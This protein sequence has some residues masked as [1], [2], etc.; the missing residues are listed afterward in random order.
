MPLRD[1][2]SPPRRFR[3]RTFRVSETELARLHAGIRSASPCRL[4]ER[5][6]YVT[7]RDLRRQFSY[8]GGMMRRTLSTAV[9][10][11]LFLRLDSGV[12]AQSAGGDGPLPEAAQFLERVR[13]NIFRQY[14]DAIL[15]NGYA[16]H[17]KSTRDSVTDEGKTKDRSIEESDVINKDGLPLYKLVSKDGKPLSEKEAAKKEYK[18]LNRGPFNRPKTGEEAMQEAK[19]FVDDLFRVMDFKIL[20]RE[21]VR[22]RPAIVVEFSPRKNAKP[23]TRAGKMVL[24]RSKGEA[25]VDEADFVLMRFQSRFVEDLTWGTGLMAKVYKG[26]EVVREWLK[27]RDEVWLPARSETRFKARIFLVKGFNFRRVEEFSDYKKFS[28]ETIIKVVDGPK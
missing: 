21:N 5:H 7:E 1:G 24:T 15:L 18:P 20:R 3:R 17:V 6:F 10:L 28:S 26:T 12:R 23:K 8:D 16:Y 4:P 9:F 19:A 27:F 11:L 13:Q 14:D 22:N 2:E 25:W